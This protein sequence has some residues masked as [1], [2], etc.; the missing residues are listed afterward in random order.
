MEP[1]DNDRSDLRGGS[2]APS[3]KWERFQFHTEQARRPCLKL[4][5]MELWHSE[6]EWLCWPVDDCRPRKAGYL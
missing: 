6:T 1:S 2:Y 4:L 5:R 3:R